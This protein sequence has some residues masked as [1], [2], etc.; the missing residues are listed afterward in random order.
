MARLTR[1]RFEARVERAATRPS[2]PR[3]AARRAADAQPAP[4]R[5]AIVDRSPAT[6][7]A[8]GDALFPTTRMLD[9]LVDDL[10]A[11]VPR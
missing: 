10:N 6:P 7:A 9:A 2:T 8:G 3:P 4:A 5:R 1:P 11:P